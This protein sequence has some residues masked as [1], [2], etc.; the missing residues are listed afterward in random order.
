METLITKNSNQIHQAFNAFVVIHMVHTEHQ[1]IVIWIV[2]EI[3]M[4]F[5]VVHGQI[6]FIQHQ[7]LVVIFFIDI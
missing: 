1:Q 7:P 5:V 3:Q 2:V 4:R 6:L